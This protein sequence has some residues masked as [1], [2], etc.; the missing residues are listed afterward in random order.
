MKPIAI[1]GGTF[2]PI[3]IAHLRV[4]VEAFEALDA[5]VRL[6]PANV[7]PHR[8]QPLATAQQRLTMLRLAVAGQPQLRI[9]D[10][11]LHREGPSYTVDTLRGLR[12]ELG[13]SLPLILLLGADA[14][15]GLSTWHRWRDLFSLAHIVV[16]TRPGHGGVFEA[17]LASEWFTRR[18]ADRGALHDRPCGSILPLQVTPLEI[19]ASAIRATLARGGSVRYLVPDAVAEY[20]ARERLYD[21]ASQA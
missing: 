17:E 16:L 15:G 14:F 19:S 5:E 7:P 1:L 9:D 8:S 6:M 12:A 21:A 11:E 18:V 13:A 10:R 3:H 4:A 2:D 20:I